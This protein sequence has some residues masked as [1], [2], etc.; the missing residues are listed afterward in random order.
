MQR[1]LITGATGLVGHGLKESLSQYQVF[2]PQG[3][4]ELDL[5][6]EKSVVNYVNNIKP[7]FVIHC[8]ALA[9]VEECEKNKQLANDINIK[10]TS[11]LIN[12]CSN[13]TKRLIYIS[14]DLVFENQVAPELGFREADLTS[15]FSHY[16]HT[17]LVGE[18]IAYASKIPEVSIF[19]LSLVLSP[20]PKRGY[21]RETLNK[22]NSG[23]T[24]QMYNDEWRTPIFL[25]DLSRG[26]NNFIELNSCERRNI[27]HIG[28]I[29]R[30]SRY[31]LGTKIADIWGHNSLQIQGKLSSTHTG[32]VP[33]AKDVSLNS[34][35]F[36]KL[37]KLTPTRL[38]EGLRQIRSE[39]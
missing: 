22:L 24:L 8:A 15:T 29:E 35:K 32:L 4:E 26:V 6:D 5:R 9:N 13:I 30:A 2:S 31:E 38:I 28:G 10:G 17:K 23:Q 16:A 18:S 7:D 37:V 19:R 36:W 39:L 14:T 21:L 27:Y 34:T 25:N 12:A 11:N 3:S 1:I 20:H 33:R